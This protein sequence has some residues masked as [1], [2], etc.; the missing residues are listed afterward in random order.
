MVRNE[1]IE[2]V[3]GDNMRLGERSAIGI[4]GHVVEHAK[5]DVDDRK[6]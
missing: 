5:M 6:S 3:T 2:D 4:Q 1:Q